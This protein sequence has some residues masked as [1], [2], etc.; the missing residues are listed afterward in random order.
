MQTGQIES[1]GF[2]GLRSCFVASLFLSLLLAPS[3]VRAVTVTWDGGASTGAWATGTNWSTNL[4]PA[5]AND[6]I[7]D[8]AGANGQYS[9]TLGANRTTA[10][11]VFSSA[12]GTNLLLG[13]QTNITSGPDFGGSPHKGGSKIRT[14]SIR[15]EA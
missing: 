2:V 3:N 9:I 14:R 4:V 5:N 10:G 7:F 6:L 13:P 11:I 12:A 8:A 15:L 1:N